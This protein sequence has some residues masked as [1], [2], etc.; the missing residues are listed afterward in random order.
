MLLLLVIISWLFLLTNLV[1]LSH[2]HSFILYHTEHETNSFRHDCLYY[3]VQESRV[4]SAISKGVVHEIIEYCLRPLIDPVHKTSIHNYEES[5]TAFNTLCTQNIT[6]RQ[7][8]AWSAPIDLVESYQAYLEGAPLPSSLFY[9]CSSPY[10]GHDCRYSFFFNDLYSSFSDVVKIT[11][12]AKRKFGGSLNTIT[13]LTCYM[14]LECHHTIARCI[15]WREICDGKVDCLNGGQDEADC[16]ILEMNECINDTEFRCRNGAHC[17]PLEFLGD[18]EIIPDCIDRSDEFARYFSD[19]PRCFEEPGV[20]CEES[21]CGLHA[22]S[23]ECCG[24]GQCAYPYECT[25]QRVHFRLDSWM[26]TWSDSTETNCSLAVSCHT[27]LLMIVL[28]DDRCKQYCS[29][30]SVSFIRG[31]CPPLF[32]FPPFL[33]IFGHVRLLYTNNQSNYRDFGTSAIPTYICYAEELCINVPSLNPPDIRFNNMTCQFTFK[34]MAHTK[35]RQWRTS[36]AVLI[37]IL[38]EIFHVCLPLI[39]TRTNECMSYITAKNLYH[40]ANASKCISNYRLNDKVVNCPLGDDENNVKSSHSIGEYHNNSYDSS[41]QAKLEK[42]MLLQHQDE[43]QVR[44]TL[45][46][47]VEKEPQFLFS[48]LCDGYTDLRVVSFDGFNHTDE[49]ECEH[50]PCNNTYTRCD[51]VWSCANGADEVNCPPSTCPLLHHM[52]VSPYTF[53]LECLPIKQANDGIIDCLGSSDER[54]SCRF[55]LTTD[56]PFNLYRCWNDTTCLMVSSLC[57]R[58]QNCQ[59]ADD[60]LFCS[61]K[62]IQ[63][64]FCVPVGRNPVEEVLCGIRHGVQLRDRYLSLRENFAPVN[65]HTIEITTATV[66]TLMAKQSRNKVSLV[67]LK[68]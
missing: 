53:E 18:D 5:G 41:S 33:A 63:R 8:L 15:D 17:I 66:T 13:N 68:V 31:N 55:P 3:Y 45:T 35:I 62:S 67:S 20:R 4:E 24:D 64:G 36:V 48:V 49:S 42:Y 22:Y 56:E 29:D 14:H 50:F 10:F 16:F 52:C 6:S 43:T 1:Y 39:P 60:E 37:S 12:M 51:G 27:N 7:L 38:H 46:S 23:R 30:S 26:R 61:Q 44:S 28:P 32:F 11:F 65:Y 2:M 19:L 40:C 57:N 58:K 59:F 25:N 47:A 9:N 21:V 34:V 54:Q